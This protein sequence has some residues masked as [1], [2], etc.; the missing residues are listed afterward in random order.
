MKVE[1]L[2][3]VC[4]PFC[5]EKIRLGNV[6]QFYEDDK[7]N[8]RFGEVECS[9]GISKIIEGILLFRK[10]EVKEFR[11]F[12]RK[13]FRVVLYF[14]S[15][16][17]FNFEQCLKFLKF[18]SVYRDERLWL[19]YLIER[20]KRATFWLQRSVLKLVKGDI[21]VD[22]GC[23]AGNLAKYLK[24]KGRKVYLV[25]NNY[26]LLYLARVTNKIPKDCI[27]IVCDLESRFSFLDGV[28]DTVLA[29]DCLMYID[30]QKLFLEEIKRIGKRKAKIMLVHIHKKGAVNLA[31]GNG[32]SLSH[33][34]IF[35]K[36]K[37]VIDDKYLWKKIL[38]GE[39]LKKEFFND[40]TR[41]FSVLANVKTRKLKLKNI[42][43][44]EI[45]YKEDE[46]WQ[47]D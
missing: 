23:G 18:V 25:D 3:I 33:F 43:K 11:F 14:R 40:N 7:K 42:K 9:C 8:I 31:Q 30:H 20:E 17:D 41:S 44:S 35:G 29:N 39:V 10:R 36:D 4:C 5:L 34:D 12:T 2:N 19:K 28:F 21:V 6:S 24:K 32:M 46:D 16:F 37:L 47:D 27:C 15:I 13:L 1:D 26:W 22:L 45:N 38:F